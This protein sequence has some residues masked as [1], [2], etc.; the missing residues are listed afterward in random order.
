[1]MY[2]YICLLNRAGGLTG[3]EQSIWAHRRRF[4]FSSAS[5][6]RYATLSKGG[7]MQSLLCD[8]KHNVHRDIF[9]RIRKV[10]AYANALSL[11]VK[12]DATVKFACARA[13]F[14]IFG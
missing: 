14:L 1:M 6:C 11:E 3:C 8:R 4:T 5:I 2:Q 7:E 13:L 9:N 10:S 12:Y